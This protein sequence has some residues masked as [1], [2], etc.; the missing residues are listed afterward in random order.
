M[1]ENQ[2]LP[3]ANEPKRTTDRKKPYQK[4][5]FRHERVFENAALSCGKI[6]AVHPNCKSARKTS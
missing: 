6:A 2:E 5:S 3:E 4:P 1:R